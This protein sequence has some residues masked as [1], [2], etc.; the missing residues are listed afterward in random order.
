MTTRRLLLVDEGE[1]GLAEELALSAPGPGWTVRLGRSEREAREQIAAGGV[2]ALVC[3]ADRTRIA[4]RSLL[5]EVREAWPATVRVAVSGEPP[6]ALAS[7]RE[8]Q[9]VAPREAPAIWMA[10]ERACA[11]QGV[12]VSPSVAAAVGR[13]GALPTAPRVH[14]E[15]RAA[16]EDRHATN[17][18]LGAIVE[19][20]PAVTAKVLQVANSAFFGSRRGISSVADAL[21]RLGARAVEAL[22]LATEVACTFPGDAPV[23]GFSLAACQAHA[24][25][26]ALVARRIGRELGAGDEA[27]CCGILHDV[28]QL[29]LADRLPE[30]FGEALAVAAAESWQLDRAEA[31]V[32]GATHGEI[33]AYL[34]A[35]WGIPE[36]AVEAIAFHHSPDRLVHDHVDLVDV[37]H[38]A[39]ALAHERES[40]RPGAAPE[41]AASHLDALG[42]AD[43]L[44]GWRAA[45]CRIH[46]GAVG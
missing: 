25:L 22:V 46:A 7:L 38:V 9:R 21:S 43:R 24:L 12:L 31:E 36:A 29:V 35:L 15:L 11:L 13:V 44:P 40:P 28:G 26:T 18:A 23:E 10:V 45:A 6:A 3:A 30:R 34:M 41:L 32:L 33:G 42:V 17:A 16:L 20:D 8:A 19:R 1:G 4:A 5:R 27:F 2:D 14:A 37:V 39:D